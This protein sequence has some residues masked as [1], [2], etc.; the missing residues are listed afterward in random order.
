MPSLYKIYETHDAFLED[1]EKNLRNGGLMLES[2]EK[3]DPRSLVEVV[4][5]IG[6][7]E[8]ASVVGEAVYVAPRGDGWQVG[9]ELRN[10]WREILE[11]LKDPPQVEKE[12]QWGSDSESL[13]HLI[14]DMETHEKINLAIKG[15][16][17]ERRILMKDAHYMVHPYLLKNPRLT[18][19]EV[20]QIAKRPNLT[21][22][23]VLTISGNREW[24]Q[25]QT[26]R[27]SIIKNP[28][29][30]ATVVQKHVGAL[31]DNDLM[32][33]AKSENVKQNVSQ[34]ARRVLA[35][36]GKIIK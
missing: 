9:V 30:P 16:R 4:L 20:A 27:L 5:R 7:K 25:N 17:A 3:V 35:A 8:V 24:M 26:V 36:R 6:I 22:E 15:G 19:D 14:R 2:E 28:K 1:F 18:Y 23:M 33:L 29:T 12:D 31:R 13:Q 10:N 21:A 32:Q 11:A 34:A